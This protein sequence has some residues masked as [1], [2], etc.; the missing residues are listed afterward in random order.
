MTRWLCTGMIIPSTRMSAVHLACMTEMLKSLQ[1]Q[2]AR[3]QRQVRHLLPAMTSQS[4]PEPPL[5]IHATEDSEAF[6]RRIRHL[7]YM[8][9]QVEGYFCELCKRWATPTH[10]TS[11][12]HM[13]KKSWFDG[14]KPDEQIYWI[15]ELHTA[16][17]LYFKAK[18]DIARGGAGHGDAVTKPSSSHASHDAADSQAGTSA[19]QENVPPPDEGHDASP[20][21]FAAAVA[22]VGDGV[23]T[24][25]SQDQSDRLL[26]QGSGN[27]NPSDSEQMDA[28]LQEDLWSVLGGFR[29]ISVKAFRAWIPL[30]VTG[31]TTML[32][33]YTTVAITMNCSSEAFS[34]FRDQQL[35]PISGS[36]GD[37]LPDEDL[38]LWAVKKPHPNAPRLST[39][40]LPVLD[41]VD[42]T[43]SSPGSEERGLLSA[44]QEVGR[45]TDNDFDV[46]QVTVRTTRGRVTYF[47]KKGFSKDRTSRPLCED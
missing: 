26:V 21:A 42:L 3:R 19:K 9:Q 15:E 45:M 43:T 7:P 2:L 5:K 36:V 4:Q 38:D 44:N 35:I 30:Y 37:W 32:D 22:G 17:Q 47:L 28:D 18:I 8:D 46:N 14:L 1:G 33:V 40:P 24:G 41:P 11:K 10:I 29:V 39:N 27:S 34:I 31:A 6:K 16:A 25:D 13:K 12:T 23:A 20:A